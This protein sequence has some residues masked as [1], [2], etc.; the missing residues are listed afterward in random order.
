[1]FAFVTFYAV[2]EGTAI[3]WIIVCKEMIQYTTKLVSTRDNTYMQPSNTAI[4][5]LLHY[6]TTKAC[7]HSTP[8]WDFTWMCNISR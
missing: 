1:M 2:E 4:S 8:N 6:L 5:L 7:V 3:E